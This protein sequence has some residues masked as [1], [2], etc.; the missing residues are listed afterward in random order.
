MQR[1]YP[2]RLRMNPPLPASLK[3]SGQRISMADL[4]P[5]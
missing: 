4:Y 5:R 2:S 3:L 1:G